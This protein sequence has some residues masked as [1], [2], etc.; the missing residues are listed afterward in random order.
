LTDPS[1]EV[2]NVLDN[3]LVLI[4]LEAQAFVPVICQQQPQEL[5][6]TLPLD[7]F[8]KAD[9]ETAV[10]VATAF[11]AFVLERCPG[12]SPWTK[13]VA[14]D[15]KRVVETRLQGKFAGLRVPQ[16]LPTEADYRLLR[17]ELYPSFPAPSV[18]STK[19][20]ISSIMQQADA[21]N[22]NQGTYARLSK[23]YAALEDALK[24]RETEEAETHKNGIRTLIGQLRSEHAAM[25]QEK[26][27]IIQERR[28]TLREDNPTVDNRMLAAYEKNLDLQ[29]Q[30]TRSLEALRDEVERAAF[31]MDVTSD[32]A[33]LDAEIANLHTISISFAVAG[34]MS[35]GKSTVVNCFTAKNLAPEDS[36]AM[37]AI[38]TR[39][40]H[41]P[42]LETP[43]LFVPFWTD[44]NHLLTKFRTKVDRASLEQIKKNGRTS[45]RVCRLIDLI[46]APGE[47]L[48]IA[49][50]YEGEERV[51]QMTQYIHDIFRLAVNDVFGDLLHPFLPMDW[52]T[53]GLNSFLTVFLQFPGLRMLNDLVLFSVVDTPGSDEEGVQ[54]LKFINSITDTVNQ[55]TF[56]ALLCDSKCIG[57]KS[58][59]ELKGIFHEAK[60]RHGTGTLFLVTQGDV[61]HVENWVSNSNAGYDDLK[62]QA[63]GNISY[64]DQ[65][66][67]SSA[68][69]FPVSAL[70][71]LA[72]S[73]M[74]NFIEKNGRVPS[75][76]G[77]AEEKAIATRFYE[78]RRS[79]EEEY[80]KVSLKGSDTVKQQA[81]KLIKNSHM[82]EPVTVMMTHALK[83]GIPASIKATYLRVEK[84]YLTFSELLGRARDTELEDQL[85]QV[86]TEVYTL[87]HE[88]RLGVE[89]VLT[90]AEENLNARVKVLR[91]TLLPDICLRASRDGPFAQQL[92]REMVAMTQTDD[93]PPVYQHKYFKT[94]KSLKFAQHLL[95]DDG[96]LSCDSREV[97]FET[98]LNLHWVH[99]FFS[100]SFSSSVYI[101][102]TFSPRIDLPKS[103]RKGPDRLPR[104]S[105]EKT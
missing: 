49:K 99:F 65:P 67:F 78:L 11:V 39:Y 51:R 93:E 40:V 85:R 82:N 12:F 23:S 54:K 35:V 81:E 19:Q 9:D 76:D 77:G 55:C 69:I 26:L 97:A 75:L 46:M 83:D 21:F 3:F 80:R 96:A 32:L 1:D 33:F 103:H 45:T 42:G 30:A 86:E 71:M 58:F 38:P 100:L 48:T 4:K 102:L 91:E 61:S 36:T 13:F 89:E 87:A 88:Y 52:K 63:Q 92:W 79:S 2:V 53:R 66:L 17:E 37:T 68:D 59:R 24:R 64:K 57:G 47:G 41:V 98:I 29:M 44:L 10:A 18:P 34:V 70:Q 104:C 31:H 101:F 14:Q 20:I 16:A 27:R 15:T 90:S 73:R 5:K 105:P 25:C 84:W 50:E 72:G 8:L 62:R 28:R 7:W 95:T 22:V 60:N 74:V 6:T 94:D 43:V 56:A